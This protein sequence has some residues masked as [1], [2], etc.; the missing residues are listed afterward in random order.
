MML[1]KASSKIKLPVLNSEIPILDFYK[2]TPW[3]VLIFHLYLLINLFLHTTKYTRW[4]DAGNNNPSYL[5]TFVFNYSYKNVYNKIITL[6]I[7]FIIM[8]LYYFLPILTL[9]WTAYKFL[10][11]HD[12]TITLIND[13]IIT[14][15]GLM[16]VYVYWHITKLFQV[17]RLKYLIIV[18]IISL[19]LILG[20]W[21]IISIPKNNDNPLG[22]KFHR[23]LVII[24]KPISYTE[25]SDIIIAHYLRDNKTK[26]D[27]LRGQAEKLDLNG[28][29][30]SYS[31]FADSIFIKTEL[32]GAN[33][34]GAVLYGANLQGA[35]LD[36]ANLQGA[37]LS[38]ANL[39]GAD[40]S[41]ANLNCSNI[42]NNTDLRG[43]Y[44]GDI[45]KLF[46]WNKDTE[47]DAKT[48]EQC[49]SFDAKSKAELIQR[50]ESN[51]NPKLFIDI[52]KDLA[53]RN[54]ELAKSISNRSITVIF[55]NGTE[56]QFGEVI[57]VHIKEKC[58][59]YLNTKQH[60]G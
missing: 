54:A 57:E 56:V 37:D 41:S 52:N 35:V 33:L 30:L 42:D 27:A 34:H 5:A 32:I 16:S 21:Y 60:K 12:K 22:I 55:D 36:S 47:I 13:I 28:R 4:L 20:S 2:F 26:A 53:C 58:P 18:S 29:D 17:H 24:D 8:V 25:V 46:E 23:S 10:P 59:Q 48:A 14:F 45:N 43:I 19:C 11:Y 9:I 15:D 7:N 44:Y 39:Q 38:S 6:I 40:L 50:L 51:K 1:L 3:V 31:N 49:K